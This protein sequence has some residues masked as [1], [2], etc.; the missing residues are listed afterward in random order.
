M[1]S[2]RRAGWCIFDI[3]IP[4]SIDLIVSYTIQGVNLFILILWTR[5]YSSTMF[6][7]LTVKRTAIVVG[8]T[9]L[10]PHTSRFNVFVI[11]V[12]ALASFTFGYTNN[13]IAGTLAQ[14]TFA[15]KF[16]VDED[17]PSVIGGILGG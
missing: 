12:A 8:E 5:K 3:D 16:F 17:V 13:A 11:V 4:T 15:A 6:D 2:L 1:L 14:T 10:A 9:R 7:N